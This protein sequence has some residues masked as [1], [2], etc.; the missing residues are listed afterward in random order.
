L[1]ESFTNE[2]LLVTDLR[3]SGAANEGTLEVAHEALFR[4]WARLREWI[5]ARKG[6]FLLRKR[7]QRASVDWQRL[8]K[9][10]AY[11]WSDE[12]TLR[13]AEAIAELSYTPTPLEREFLGPIDVRDMLSKIES[14]ETTHEERVTIGLRLAQL[15]DPRPGVGLRPDG[16]PD[17]A[18]CPVK[19]GEVFL[20]SGAG[21]FE[22][23]AFWISK[24]PIT[25]QQYRAF[26]E[27]SDG[28]MNPKWWEELDVSHDREPD[29][30]FPPVN[31][32]PAVYVSWGEAVA[33]SRW[34]SARL[35]SE[36]SLPKIWYR[37]IR[38]PTEWEWQQAA[39][40]SH[41][42]FDYPWG[43]AWDAR[44]AN[45]AESKLHRLVSVGLYAQDYPA[46]RPLDMAGNT[47]EWCLNEYENTVPI[48]EI[49]MSGN[50]DRSLRGGSWHFD[51]SRA[52]CVYR[53]L[54]HFDYPDPVFS[55]RLTRP[56]ARD[57]STE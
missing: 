15:G 42:D 46:N 54:I 39:T 55:F 6:H 44:R 2:R 12:R 17:I 19:G 37:R 3:N 11:K 34:L 1:I 57:P 38:L 8:G 24:Y 23:Q 31:N 32:H 52:R 43:P 35:E 7:L 26:I 10:A 30:Q 50:R 22:V 47:L 28:F 5:E 29:V 20:A 33:Y 14:Y 18:W 53:A 13:A 51:A 40:D 45:T 4:S 9:P 16:L 36:Y 49:L 25:Y 21:P 48:G 27:A 41:T 56:Y